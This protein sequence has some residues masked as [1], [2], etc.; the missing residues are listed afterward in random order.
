[1]KYATRN[2]KNKIYDKSFVF[3][4][5]DDLLNAVRKTALENH[6]SIASFIRQSVKRNI[7][8]Y[9]RLEK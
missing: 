1:L 5:N 8:T 2:R 3:M 9:E 7:A 4:C 6:L